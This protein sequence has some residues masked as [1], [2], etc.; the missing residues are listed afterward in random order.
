MINKSKTIKKKKRHK[1]AN[2]QRSVKIDTNCYEVVTSISLF[3]YIY[4]FTLTPQHTDI[5]CEK[6]AIKN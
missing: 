3:G 2:K 4:I 1:Q 6:S 5:A